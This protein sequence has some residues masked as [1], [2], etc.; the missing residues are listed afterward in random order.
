MA[1]GRRSPDRTS[2]PSGV[3]FKPDRFLLSAVRRFRVLS[4]SDTIDKIESALDRA[5]LR[6]HEW[7]QI[8]S[9]FTSDESISP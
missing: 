3:G 6:R 4:A 1:S 5:W 7:G 9:G 2:A 8:G